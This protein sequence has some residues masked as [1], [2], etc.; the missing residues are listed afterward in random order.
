MSAE[1][2][3]DTERIYREWDAALSRN[4]MDALLALYAD[5]AELQSPVVAH[6]MNRERGVC[7]GKAEVMEIENGFIQKHRVYWGWF[8]FGV[9]KKDQ[10]R[11]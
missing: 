10:Y 8:G 7:R 3:S 5:D 1:S 9:L 2:N 6:L 11:T 4:D